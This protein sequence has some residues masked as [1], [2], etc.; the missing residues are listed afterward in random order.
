MA[1]LVLCYH[2]Q[3]LRGNAQSLGFEM[4]PCT[5]ALLQLYKTLYMKKIKNQVMKI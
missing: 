5:V 2:N 3:Q 1:C 4:G